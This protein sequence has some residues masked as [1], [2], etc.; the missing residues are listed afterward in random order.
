MDIID[1]MLAKAMTPQGQTETYVAKAN[2]AA[3]KAAKAQEDAEAAV[4]IVTS[5]ASDIAD[6]Q[7]AAATLLETAE[8]ALAT[9]QAAQG[10]LPTAYSTT[11]QNTDGYMTQKAVTDALAAKA[12]TS[13]LAAKADKTYVDQQI[14]AIPSSGSGSETVINMDPADANHLVKVDSNGNLVASLA[15]EDAVV[16]AL[17]RSGSYEAVNAVGLDVDYANRTFT[18]IQGATGKSMGSDFNAYTMYG[19]RMRCNVGDD[20]YINAFYGDSG[21]KEDGSNGQVMVYQPKFYYKRIIRV[22]DELA[23]G[24]AVRHETLILSSTAQPGLKLAPIFAGDLDYILLPAFD[25]GLVNSKLTSIAGVKPIT[26]ITIAAAEDY[27][28]ARG[29]GWHIM[30]MAAESANQMLEMVEF[31]MLNGQAAI[32]QG[33]TWAPNGN[34]I[35]FITGSTSSLGNGTGH[36]ISTNVE[37][38]GSVTVMD[39]EGYRAISYRGMENPWGNLW[40]MI[41]GVNINGN[42]VQSGGTIYLCNDFN[43]TPGEVG[44]NYTDIG[45]NLPSVYGWVNAM[46]IGNEDY[47]WVYM[48]VECS[49]S[50]NSYAPVGDE[51]WTVGNLNGS[52]IL[53]TGGSYG[54]KDSCG[55]FYYAADR[56][57][58]DSARYNYGAKLLYIPTKNTNYTANITKWQAHMGG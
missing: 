52:V 9:A 14:A 2:A 25:A 50:A 13:D 21:Y 11:G 19:G 28:N 48:P 58:Q 49:T 37:V 41:G 8:A 38:N 31:G 35:F 34:S 4:A 54:Q 1:I 15:T 47:D 22:S 27:A 16:E 10:E 20:G 17:L 12:S 6:A 42:G 36:A 43:Y 45:F 18:R 32:E 29:Q 44:N 40:S 46:G 7:S 55:P 33:I 53:A 24:R 26:N 5:A 23:K 56:A 39:Q 3:A 57:A 30:N 51:L